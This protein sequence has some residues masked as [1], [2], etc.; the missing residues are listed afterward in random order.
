MPAD[1]QKGGIGD[2]Q[3]VVPTQRSIA[4]PLLRGWTYDRDSAPVWS[5]TNYL[6]TISIHTQKHPDRLQA[7]RK[8][9]PGQLAPL[10]PEPCLCHSKSKHARETCSYSLW[11]HREDS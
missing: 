4:F 7:Q 3:Y 11:L 8:H 6:T 1:Y 5:L 9:K 2:K 10:G